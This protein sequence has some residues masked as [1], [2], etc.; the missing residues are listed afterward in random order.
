MDKG[1]TLT[2]CRMSPLLS[3]N[4]QSPTGS[5]IHME[6]THLSLKLTKLPSSLTLKGSA[7]GN[8]SGTAGPSGSLG[9][10]FDTGETYFCSPFKMNLAEVTSPAGISENGSKGNEC[11]GKLAAARRG[12]AEAGAEEGPGGWEA[13]AGEGWFC[14][15]R[16]L[17]SPGA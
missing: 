5:K 12:P 17:L 1:T 7:K 16:G 9:L 13:G 8:T 4:N 15:G 2:S 6:L 3:L 10:H 11:A 14:S